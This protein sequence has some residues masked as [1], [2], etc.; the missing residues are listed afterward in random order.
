MDNSTSTAEETS[1]TEIN[2]KRRRIVVEAMWLQYYND[3]LLEKQ[4]ISPTMHR[5]MRL[6]ISIRKTQKLKQLR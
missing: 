4:L 6:E 3:T 2:E 5:K 1:N